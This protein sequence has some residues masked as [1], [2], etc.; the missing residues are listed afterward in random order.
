MERSQKFKWAKVSFKS[1]HT[2]SQGVKTE[3]KASAYNN[4]LGQLQQLPAALQLLPPANHPNL[5]QPPHN[6][7]SYFAITQYYYDTNT[8][9]NVYL[10]MLHHLIQRNVKK[11]QQRLF[12]GQFFW[13][14]ENI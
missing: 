12:S 8:Y 14:A 13:G 6:M 10:I 4:Y 2:T 11:K 7:W 3:G 1:P 9:F 5:Q